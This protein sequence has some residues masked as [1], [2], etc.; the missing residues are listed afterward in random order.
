MSILIF[1]SIMQMYLYTFGFSLFIGFFLW[2]LLL[3]TDTL[4]VRGWNKQK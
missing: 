1:S 3:G 4:S 2:L